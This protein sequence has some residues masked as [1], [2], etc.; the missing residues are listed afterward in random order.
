MTGMPK[1]GADEPKPD[2]ACL[3]SALTSIRPAPTSLRPIRPSSPRRRRFGVSKA[4][5]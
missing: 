3:R 1:A 5:G 4:G 2:P